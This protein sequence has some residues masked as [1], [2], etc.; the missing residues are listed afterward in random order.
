MQS[1][2]SWVDVAKGIGII[3]VVYGH[4]ARGLVSAHLMPDDAVFRMVDSA[5]YSFHMP[6]FSFFLEY[7]SGGALFLKDLPYWSLPRS[8]P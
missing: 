3:L 8:T 2:L 4:I 7:S 5:I 6:L 1:R